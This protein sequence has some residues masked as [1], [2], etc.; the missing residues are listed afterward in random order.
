MSIFNIIRP[1]YRNS[2]PATRIQGINKLQDDDIIY[3]MAMNDISIDVRM[4]ALQRLSDPNL[5]HKVATKSKDF[6]LRKEATK[7]IHDAELLSDIV[8]LVVQL[9]P[10]VTTTA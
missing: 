7:N 2:K 10:S 4:A 6:E 1:K 8:L 3:D 5:L 9:F